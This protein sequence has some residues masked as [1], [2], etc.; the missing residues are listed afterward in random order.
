MT[1]R[2][3]VV[4]PFFDF[5]GLPWN[6]KPYSPDQIPEQW[7]N[8]LLDSGSL[9]QRLKQE[10]QN[11]F[12]VRVVKHEC[13]MPT[14]SEQN[15]LN[16]PAIEAN[17]REVLLICDDK[18]RVFARSVLPL[19]SLEGANR[20]LLEL[21]NRPLG[22]FLFTHPAMKRGPFEIAAL[23]ARQF[24]AHLDQSYENETAW[25]RR[26]LFYLNDKPISVCEIFLPDYSNHDEENLHDK[27]VTHVT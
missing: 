25:G 12:K 1:V 10:C 21:G 27:E 18:P 13:E 15:F 8:W 2:N 23:P 19:T 20:E 5:T 22:E 6:P 26:S 4:V 14:D 3:G 9:T 11:S 7:R 24:N 17:I 16:Q